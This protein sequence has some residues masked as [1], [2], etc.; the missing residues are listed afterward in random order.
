MTTHEAFSPTANSTKTDEQKF[1][2][3]RSK[4]ED[5]YPNYYGGALV[6]FVLRAAG[7]MSKRR[8]VRQLDKPAE[9]QTSKPLN[10]LFRVLVGVL[11]A[12]KGDQGGWEGGARGL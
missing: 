11:S 3:I 7:S 9:Q 10:R 5:T 12:P 4:F 6:G 2:A 8:N 1:R